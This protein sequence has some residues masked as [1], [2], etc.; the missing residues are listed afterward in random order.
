MSK[1]WILP[2]TAMVRGTMMATQR[3]LLQATQTQFHVLSR[4][5]PIVPAVTG[6][7]AASLLSAVLTTATEFDPEAVIKLVGPVDPF[8]LRIDRHATRSTPHRDGCDDLGRLV[9][10]DVNHADIGCAH[11]GHVQLAGLGAQRH[12][13]TETCFREILGHRPRECGRQKKQDSRQSAHATSSPSSLAS[14]YGTQN[15]FFHSS[16][17]PPTHGSRPA[18]SGSAAA[19]TDCTR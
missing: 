10:L 7:E 2:H 8:G 6:M 9:R 4:P 12:P 5:R 19:R 11:V 14:G 3:A 13:V 17:H 1:P 18:K 15:H 16:D